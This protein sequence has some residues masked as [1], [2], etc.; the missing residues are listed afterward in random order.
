LLAVPTQWVAPVTTT[1]AMAVLLLSVVV[2][3][4][5]TGQLSLCQFALA[6]FG[7][8]VAV[9]TAAIWGVPFGWAVLVGIAGGTVL[10]VLIALPA[11]RTRG[12]NLAIA[13]LALALMI[14]SMIFNN[15]SLTGGYYGSVVKPPTLF[16]VNLNP[17]IEPRNYGVFAAASLALVAVLVANVRRGQSG[18]RLLAVRSN[19]R[20]AAGLGVS[21]AGAKIFAFGF[22]AAIAALAG[23]LLSFQTNNITF[24]AFDAPGSINAVLYAMLGGVGFIVGG[25]LGAQF[26]V[27][28]VGGM[29]ATT[30]FGN[31]PNISG[32]LLLF[33]GANMLLILM[34]APGGIASMLFPSRAGE[35]KSARRSPLVFASALSQSAEIL[36]KRV[37]GRWTRPESTVT[38]AVRRD[39]SK[40]EVRDL[41]VRFGSVVALD[42]VSFEVRPGEVVGLIGPNG[43][44]KTTILDVL[45]GFTKPAAGQVLLDGRA[46]NRWSP[47]RRAR[48]GVSRSWQSLELFEDMTVLENLLVGADRHRSSD[49]FID[50]VHPNR[51][52]NTEAVVEM[53]M[54]FGLDECLDQYPTSLSHGSERLVSIARSMVINPAV[55][56]LDEPA[57]GLDANEREQIGRAIRRL[58]KERGIGVLLIEHDMALVL[59][60]SDRIVCL[61]FGIKIAE[62]TCEE[63]VADENVIQAYLGV[64]AESIT[65]GGGRD[66]VH[67]AGHQ[68]LQGAD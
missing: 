2:I 19:E 14:N 20:A 40:V 46:I 1:V 3:T 35:S 48:N 57:A 56:L 4:G 60:V 51:P 45:T 26:V 62:G 43:A 64:N 12:I 21:I 54:E 58:A 36:W 9:R 30:L 41:S 50:I 34:R 44:G 66:A 39:P 13:T 42:H 27:G 68:L 5:Y 16:G 65:A 52:V 11:I 28:G 6:G 55:L 24:A 17:I 8:W 32:W 33:T 67:A 63:I 22:A 37:I 61:D 25:I 49:Y 59:S 31:V 29:V 15:G 23:I 47:E 18:R 7:G 53:S 38:T 10:G